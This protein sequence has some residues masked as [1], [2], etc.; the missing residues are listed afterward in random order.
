MKVC[1]SANN[2]CSSCAPPQL[3][4][5][6]LTAGSDNAGLLHEP[7]LGGECP[8]GGGYGMK[9]IQQLQDYQCL[10]DG[11]GNGDRT[12]FNCSTVY[13][14][15]Y[16]NK[17]DSYGRLITDQEITDSGG[18]NGS[19][20]VGTLDSGPCYPENYKLIGKRNIK[21]INGEAV[22]N[23]NFLEYTFPCQEGSDPARS[24]W[25]GSCATAGE[26]DSETCD[27]RSSAFSEEQCDEG[28]I[29]TSVKEKLSN[30]QS[31]QDRYNSYIKPATNKIFTLK[32]NNSLHSNGGGGVIRCGS[33]GKDDCWSTVESIYFPP[34]IDGCTAGNSRIALRVATYQENF[35]KT[36]KSIGGKVI[37]YDGGI[38]GTTPCC[39]NNFNGTIGAQYSFTLIGSN[40]FNPNGLA[41]TASNLGELNS[42]DYNGEAFSI[43]ISI[44]KIEFL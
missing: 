7:F 2:G 26:Y 15:K 10:A 9:T 33:G 23:T 28:Y 11:Y 40:N 18:A 6:G 20:I 43:C 29:G 36:Y 16:T 17:I 35:S 27:S 32:K 44:D 21:I 3:F 31:L 19:L 1:N 8:C 4:I 22:N 14:N 25:Y 5:Y 42:A 37:L 39:N 34:D 41:L 38:P 12:T 13:T 24:P 30:Y